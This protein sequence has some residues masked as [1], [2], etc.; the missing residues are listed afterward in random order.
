MEQN[1]IKSGIGSCI[2]PKS[3]LARHP[4]GK[5]GTWISGSL[6]SG[7]LVTGCPVPGSSWGDPDAPPP[8][9]EGESPW[10]LMAGYK[11]LGLIVFI[12]Y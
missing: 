6:D 10:S 7:V 4:A 9:T 2:A 8:S 3:G 11:F 12:S 1:K 5:F